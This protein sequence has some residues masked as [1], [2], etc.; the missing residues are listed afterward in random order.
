MNTCIMNSTPS[1]ISFCCQNLAIIHSKSKHMTIWT[2]QAL[3]SQN[4]GY[5]FKI[6][7]HDYLN[8]PSSP[9]S[10]FGYP[11][12]IKT[13]D[14]LNSSLLL[15]VYLVDKTLQNQEPSREIHIYVHCTYYTIHLQLTITVFPWIEAQ[16]ILRI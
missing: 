15:I 3:P 16:H 9:Q 11:F 2:V 7:T 13:H 10:K 14:Y 8:S 1:M 12:K 5:P 6:K 4:L